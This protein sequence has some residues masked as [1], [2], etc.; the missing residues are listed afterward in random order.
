MPYADLLRQ[1]V[2]HLTEIA[3]LGV[4]SADDVWVKAGADDTT[5]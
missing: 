4:R 1:A 5:A 3:E 2:D